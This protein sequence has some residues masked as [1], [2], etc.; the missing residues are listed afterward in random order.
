MAVLDT[1]VIR[2]LEEILP[3]RFGG[4]P[5][6]YQLVED[7]AGDGRS[8]VRLLVHPAVGIVEEGAVAEAFLSA[9]A[10]VSETQRLM[11]TQWRQAGLPVVERRAPFVTGSGKVLHLHQLRGGGL[12]ASALRGG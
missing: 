1:D 7:E 11:A 10:Q 12:S 9:L 2:V 5:L 6:D 8:L 4:G 3:A